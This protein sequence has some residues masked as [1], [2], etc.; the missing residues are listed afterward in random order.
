MEYIKEKLY[1]AWE[2]VKAWFKRSQVI[3]LA[4]L[5]AG[6]GFVVVA[7][8]VADWG[9]LFTTGLTW[10]QTTTL[11]AIMFVKGV[12][13]EWARRMNTIEV[14]GRLLPTDVTVQEAA[15]VVEIKAVEKSIT[16]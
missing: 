7:L 15:A 3:F 11:G 12:I 6:V 13:T 2:A 4:R 14:A 16:K 8:S 1:A 5:E 9:P 10:A